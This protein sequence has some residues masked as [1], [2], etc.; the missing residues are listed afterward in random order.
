VR[1]P[2]MLLHFRLF[3]Y[4]SDTSE[5]FGGAAISYGEGR[6]KRLYSQVNIAAKIIKRSQV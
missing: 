2:G 4:A 1:K 6:K 3:S 5:G